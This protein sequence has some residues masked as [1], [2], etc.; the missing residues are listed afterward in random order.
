MKAHVL[1]RIR[2]GETP[3]AV[4]QMRQI[5]GVLEANATFGPYD[6]VVIIEG[7]DLATLGRL[8]TGEIQPVVGVQETLTCVVIDI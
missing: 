3:E 2:A 4:G 8:V 1:I 5:K 6:A 7:K